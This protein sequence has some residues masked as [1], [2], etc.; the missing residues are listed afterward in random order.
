MAFNIGFHGLLQFRNMLSSIQSGD[1]D[2]AADHLLDSL[3]ARQ[4]PRRAWRLSNI[5]RSGKI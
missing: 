3:Y 2:K 5:L 4:V 1:L